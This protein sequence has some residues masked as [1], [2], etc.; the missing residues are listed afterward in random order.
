MR[1]AK[2]IE[3]EGDGAV[4][5]CRAFHEHL[6]LRGQ[7][8]M[9]C[10]LLPDQIAAWSPKNTSV[11]LSPLAADILVDAG[12]A[13]YKRLR[14]IRHTEW[15]DFEGPGEPITG[16]AGSL[17]STVRTAFS[18]VAGV[19]V[20]LA[21][22]T[23]KMRKA[24]KSSTERP[25]ETDGTLANGNTNELANGTPQAAA[26]SGL[27]ASELDRQLHLR[28]PTD[29]PEEYAGDLAHGVGRT[30]Y[31]IAKAPV[32]LSMALAQGF[33]NAPRL[34]GDDTVR[35]PTRVTGVRSGLRAARKEF[36]Y[37]VYDGF[38]GV[39]RLPVRGARNDGVAGFV[40]GAG[41]GL[42]GFVIKNVGAVVGPA[43]YA[44][45]GLVKQAE[46]S[47]S[48]QK[49]VRRARIAQGQR[50]GAALPG[51][52]LGELERRVADGYHAMRDLGDAIREEARERGLA[53][54]LD[55]VLVD[56]GVLFESVDVSKRA[57][58]ALRRGES[59]ESVLQPFAGKKRGG[60]IPQVRKTLNRRRA[61]TLP[62]RQGDGN[63]V[64]KEPRAR[65][66]TS[67]T[68]DRGP[69]LASASLSRS[70]TAGL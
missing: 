63:Q 45:K 22:T 17:A 41:M 15:N 5:A 48:P 37:G 21:R 25:K 18:G 35:R 55:R 14:L 8:T 62:A 65:N 68:E 43:G 9:R 13:S 42:F 19:P 70:M 20:H 52:A 40:K 10:S 67:R 59:L 51:A 23:R 54:Q 12:Y 64:G 32:D 47:R 16:I 26:S 36:A 3:R 60:A 69:G 4:N 33:H 61:A 58:A 46:R 29:L 11:K 39:V 7:H 28:A 27:P 38:T 44:M 1:V 53:G 30:A 34:Y 56:T 49:F 2:A 24:R 66:G 57:L 6:N 31:A 50:A